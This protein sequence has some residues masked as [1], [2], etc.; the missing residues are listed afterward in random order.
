M[1]ALT[2]GV[3]KYVART[4]GVTSG[5]KSVSDVARTS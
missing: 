1:I 5:N 4:V 2:N 3:A